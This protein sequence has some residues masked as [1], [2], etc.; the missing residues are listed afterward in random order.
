MNVIF[1]GTPDFAVPCLQK[2][3]KNH[4]VI[5]VFSQPDKPVGRKQVLMQTPVKACAI[6]HNI[7]VFQ[8]TSLKNDDVSAQIENMNADV[9]VVVAYGKILPKKIL[10]AAKYG[11][12]NVH[13]SL[14]PKYRGAAPIQWSVIN[15]D[16]ETGVTVMQM[17]E[18]L[19]TGDI[20][21]IEK[22][23]IGD[24]ETSEE[25]FNRLSLIG[26]DALI[27]ALDDIEKGISKPI[28]QGKSDNSY[29]EKI[30][31]ALS[32]IDWN[33]SAVEVHNLVRGLQTWPCAQTKLNGKNIK[34]HKSVLTDITG[35]K[36]GEVIENNKKLIVSCGDGHCIEI[37]EVQLD[38]KKRMD[39]KSF[40]MGNKIEI[41]A[42]LGE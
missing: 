24:N 33:K 20:L 7:D 38:G 30:T 21:R 29:A 22:T 26:A 27:K 31:K 25:L 3:I 36:A 10:E 13:A 39:T 6:E 16:K 19:D 32:P 41:G 28:P 42:L 17:D 1:M 12:I 11:C 8:P 37:L 4:N 34:I 5:A 2:L 9:I 18:G 14:L 23:E 40:L 35:A 15:G